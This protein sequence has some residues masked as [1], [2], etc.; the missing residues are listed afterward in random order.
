MI[1]LESVET[2]QGTVTLARAE[3]DDLAA[4]LDVFD[5]SLAGMVA[6][7]NTLQ[8]GT[9][10]FTQLP[11]MVERFRQHLANDVCYVALKEGD[12]VGA[13]VVNCTHP[14]YCWPNPTQN[15]AYVHPFATKPAVRGQGVG[16][17]LLHRAEQYAVEQG[18]VYLRLDCYAEQPKLCAHYERCGFAPRGEF[19][20][21]DWRGMMYEKAVAGD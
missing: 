1:P 10:P 13:L 6:Q 7:G 5:A 21:G 18:K 15:A 11:R 9:T 17:L 2:P 16:A 4:V 14:N 19:F 3:P 8:W 12:V 20:V